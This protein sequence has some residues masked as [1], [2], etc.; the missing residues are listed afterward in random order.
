M[1]EGMENSDGS[2]S[3]M[4][5]SGRVS[6]AD[7]ITGP[8]PF[9][10]LCRGNEGVDAEVIEVLDPVRLACPGGIVGSAK[11]A[12]ALLESGQIDPAHCVASRHGA[13]GA[14]I[15]AF[16][17]NVADRERHGIALVD[18]E[19]SV[20]PERVHAVDFH[21][22]AEAPS[23]LLQIDSGKPPG[24]SAQRCRRH[25]QRPVTNNV[26]SGKPSAAYRTTTGRSKYALNQSPRGDETVGKGKSH[27]G[28]WAMGTG[29]RERDRAEVGCERRPRI[30]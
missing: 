14:G 5:S 1:I 16:E 21:W 25:N 27:R 8:Q 20:L 24:D 26:S 9:S 11:I 17:P 3:D 22:S 10:M 18:A 13:A 6:A 19:E 29:R 28:D 30:R 23:R 2:N 15:H 4:Q 12:K 7:R